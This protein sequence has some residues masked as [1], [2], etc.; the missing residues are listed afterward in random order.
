MPIERGGDTESGVIFVYKIVS[1]YLS[2]HSVWVCVSVLYNI[3]SYLPTYLPTYLLPST[4]S[5]SGK[6][7]RWGNSQSKAHLPEGW[8]KPSRVG[9]VVISCCSPRCCHGIYCGPCSPLSRDEV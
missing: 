6:N 9:Q 8:G 2:C 7:L 1:L 5:G 3:V 4:S